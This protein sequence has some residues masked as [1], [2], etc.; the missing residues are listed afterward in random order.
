MRTSSKKTAHVDLLN[1]TTWQ[2]VLNILHLRNHL[3]V[4][5]VCVLNR[6]QHFATPWTVARQAPLFMEFSGQEYWSG[7]LFPTLGDL[8]N[9]GI[10]PCVSCIGRWILYHHITWEAPWNHLHARTILWTGSTL[11]RREQTQRGEEVSAGSRS[12]WAAEQGLRLTHRR[13]VTHLHPTVPAQTYSLPGAAVFPFLL[14]LI[15]VSHLWKSTFQQVPDLSGQH[16]TRASTHDPHRIT[17]LSLGNHTRS[18]WGSAQ[19]GS[20]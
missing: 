18:E 4:L 12:R 3:S 6:V 11:Q 14:M 15:L 5:S 16:L 17:L 19:T 10:V 20:E 9:P 7:Y 1:L 2:H 8:H 13:P